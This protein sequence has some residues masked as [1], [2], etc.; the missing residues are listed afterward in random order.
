MA[1]GVP[2]VQP[3]HGS[4]TEVVENTEGG[5]LFEPG[6]AEA[7]A[8]AL[9]SLYANRDFA[10]D[11]GR[12]GAEAVRREYSVEQEALRSIAVYEEQLHAVPS[13]SAPARQRT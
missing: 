10:A 6:N 12:R 5:L 11:L 8:D 9:H 2:I 4:I 7:L 13:R 1:C 3:R